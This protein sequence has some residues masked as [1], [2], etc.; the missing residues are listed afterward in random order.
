MTTGL[1]ISGI[2]KND[3]TFPQSV[4]SKKMHQ[5]HLHSAPL[6]CSLVAGLD[7]MKHGR[8]IF[9]LLF[10]AYLSPLIH[11]RPDLRYTSF[12]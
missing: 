10:V 12:I 9:L 11:P 3:A 6:K 2:L 5:L 7:V 1:G 8:A 4:T